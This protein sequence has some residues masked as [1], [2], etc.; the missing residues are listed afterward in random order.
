MKDT[1][2]A[3]AVA[4]VRS[5]ETKLLS[6]ARLESLIN[7]E[8]FD[9]CIKILSEAG[10]DGIETGDTEKALSDRL[11]KAFSLIYESAPDKNCLDFLVV[12]NDY[13][14]LKSLLK[15]MVS[16]AD[17]DGS[18]LSPSIVK[19]SVLKRSLLEKDFSQLPEFLSL[20]AKE[21]YGLVTETM[22][23]QILEVYLDR[24]CLEACEKLAED[25][26]DEFSIGVAELFT[27]LTNIRIACRCLKKG[28]DKAFLDF[29]LADC[30]LCDKEKLI[31]SVLEGEESLLNC[32]SSFGF[33]AISK[34]MKQGFAALE[35][36][37][38]DILTEKVKCAKF[39][40][41]G[42]APLAAYYFATDAEIKTVRIILSCKKNGVSEEF[43]RERVRV[44]YV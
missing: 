12:K 39:Q 40:C 17:G 23:G 30:R 42:I 21:G 31:S 44:L 41:L 14:N 33:D 20:A 15:A 27:A 32:I 28:K 29:A 26:G 8:N 18:L 5:N 13:H 25:S 3:Y 2:F 6:S 9:E 38:D 36:T 10:F 22:D 37:C 35:K 34:S 19:H 1:E 43:I 11:D 7:A 16:G 24:K 4:R